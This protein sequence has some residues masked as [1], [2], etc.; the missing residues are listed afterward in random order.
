MRLISRRFM[1]WGRDGDLPGSLLSIRFL[2]YRINYSMK[3][4]VLGLHFASMIAVLGVGGM[5]WLE[6]TIGI[7]FLVAFLSGLDRMQVRWKEMVGYFRRMESALVEYDLIRQALARE[8]IG[9][10]QIKKAMGV[11]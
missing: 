6:G 10:A 7:G 8:D 1:T 3:Y 5:M 4:A 9:R 2:F 11:A